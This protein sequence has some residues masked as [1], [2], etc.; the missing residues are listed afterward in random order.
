[1]FAWVAADKLA[2]KANQLQDGSG[3]FVL[4]LGC[5]L[6]CSYKTSVLELACAAWGCW[7]APVCADVPKGSPCH[8]FSR[9]KM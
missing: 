3:L 6:P 4:S 8:S 1:M 2:L 7:A 5:D 9:C